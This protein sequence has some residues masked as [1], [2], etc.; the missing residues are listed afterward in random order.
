MEHHFR[1]PQLKNLCSAVRTLGSATLARCLSSAPSNQFDPNPA[2][3]AVRRVHCNCL[4]YWVFEALSAPEWRSLTDGWSFAT[5][6]H[7]SGAWSQWLSMA[8]AKFSFLLHRPR[9]VQ[10]SPLR[11]TSSKHYGVCGTDCRRL[12]RHCWPSLHKSTKQPALVAEAQSEAARRPGWLK[13][14]F[15]HDH[16]G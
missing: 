2:F 1:P 9:R 11:N 8:P 6:D 7:F 12:Q 5:L 16:F 13:Q 4:N 10:P 3:P 15:L 14:Q